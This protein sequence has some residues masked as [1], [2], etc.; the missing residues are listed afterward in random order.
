MFFN[1]FREAKYTAQI[2][3]AVKGFKQPKIANLQRLESK[4]NGL[5]LLKKPPV[6]KNIPTT[7]KMVKN[8][9]NKQQINSFLYGNK[10]NNQVQSSN[11]DYLMALK[12]EVRKKNEIKNN[13]QKTKHN[14]NK[15][16][17]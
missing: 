14:F 2:S 8:T 7:V 11:P 15:L 10:A 5:D 9:N 16:P 1:D 12:Q 6:P 17:K 3:M 4:Q 13:L